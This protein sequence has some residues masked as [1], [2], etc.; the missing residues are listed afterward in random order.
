MRVIA[1][2]VGGAFGGK[3][4]VLAEHTVAIGV[5]RALGRPAVGRDPLGEPRVDA[6]GRGQVE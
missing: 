2:H 6:H 3:A 4:G 5:A 1:P